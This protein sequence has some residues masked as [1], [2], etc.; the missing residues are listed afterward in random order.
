MDLFN[1]YM[2]KYLVSTKEHLLSKDKL[3][4]NWD[5]NE[6]VELEHSLRMTKDIVLSLLHWK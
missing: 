2:L 3:Q 6:T 5:K 1:V 4:D